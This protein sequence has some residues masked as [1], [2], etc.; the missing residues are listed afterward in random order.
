MVLDFVSLQVKPSHL[1]QNFVVDCT[2]EQL[3]RD[4]HSIKYYTSYSIVGYLL[5]NIHYMVG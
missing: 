2:F 3:Y 5:L 1:R 4:Q